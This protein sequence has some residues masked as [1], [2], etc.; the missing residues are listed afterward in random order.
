[1]GRHVRAEVKPRAESCVLGWEFVAL[2]LQMSFHKKGVHKC[3]SRS[4][5][6]KR[7]GGEEE[8]RKRNKNALRG[9]TEQE[10]EMGAKP[11]GPKC[12]DK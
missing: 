6:G 2:C 12:E 4:E 9:R 7:E 1:M 3:H 5:F 10:R 11:R 8:E